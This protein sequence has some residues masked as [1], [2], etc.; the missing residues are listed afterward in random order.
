MCILQHFNFFYARASFNLC[1]YFRSR[2]PVW[3][4]RS[5]GACVESGDYFSEL[6]RHISPFVK[7]YVQ[8]VDTAKLALLHN[9]SLIMYLDPQVPKV[10]LKVR[11]QGAPPRIRG[12]RS[13]E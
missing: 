9:V 8:P 12:Q 2:M 10:S 5:V 3:S 6:R 1:F 13:V 7:L 4:L 11:F